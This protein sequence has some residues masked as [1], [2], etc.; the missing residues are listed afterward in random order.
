METGILYEF[1]SWLMDNRIS[2]RDHID[3]VTAVETFCGMNNYPKPSPE[4]VHRILSG[5]SFSN[6][7]EA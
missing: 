4:W 7:D 1:A 5:M 6:G 2:F 3:A